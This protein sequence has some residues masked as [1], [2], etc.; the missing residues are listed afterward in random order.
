MTIEPIGAASVALYLTPADLSRRGFS[1]GSLTLD[2]ALELTREACGQAGILLDGAVEIEAYPECCGVLV[3]A[4]VRPSGPVWFTFDDLEPLL[5]AALALHATAVDA[6]LWWWEDR[7]W[8]SLPPEAEGA[9]AVC[10]EFGS[11]RQVDPLLAARLEEAGQVIFPR[12]ALWEL[13]R[14]FLRLHL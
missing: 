3:F 2:Q 5:Q 14:H 11:P 8:L 12:R 6:A 10:R 1:P 4:H 13:C 7:Y 9:A